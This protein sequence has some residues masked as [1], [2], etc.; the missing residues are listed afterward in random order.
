LSRHRTGEAAM[1]CVERRKASIFC[2]AHPFRGAGMFVACMIVGAAVPVIGQSGAANGEWRVYG[3]D[4]GHTRYSPLDQIDAAN[5]SKLEVPWRFKT[6]SL[7]PRPGYQFE[8]TP[9]LA[10][11]KPHSTS[12]SRRATRAP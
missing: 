6:D 5:F 2:V 12:G 1:L 4:L 10:R 8:S 3:G 11:G 9:L 7:G